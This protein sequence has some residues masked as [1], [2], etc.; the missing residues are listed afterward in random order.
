MFTPTQNI[1]FASSSNKDPV[2]F[3]FNPMLGKTLSMLQKQ[4]Q[5]KIKAL[6][7]QYTLA[8]RQVKRNTQRRVHFRDPLVEYVQPNSAIERIKEKHIGMINNVVKD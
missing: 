8:L 6:I 5:E 3:Y 4:G 7:A 1:N 2:V